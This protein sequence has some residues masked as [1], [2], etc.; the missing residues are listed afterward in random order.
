MKNKIEDLYSRL[1]WGIEDEQKL[2]KKLYSELH[3]ESVLEYLKISEQSLL[4]EKDDKKKQS[5]V[6]VD[7]LVYGELYN[8]FEL[9]KSRLHFNEPV[10]LYINKSSEI[11][12]YALSAL[13]NNDVH[14]ISLTSSLVNM[15]SNDQLMY[16]MG[17]EI[18]HLINNDVEWKLIRSTIFPEENFY[19][20][21]LK[22]QDLYLQQLHEIKAD[23]CGCVACENLDA[24]V[25]AFLI[26]NSGIPHDRFPFNASSYLKR[27]EENVE[28]IKQ[29]ACSYNKDVHPEHP[30]RVRLMDLFFNAKNKQEL[31]AETKNVLSVLHTTVITEESK[32][33][34]LFYITAGY[35]I[36][37]IDG[38]VT[39][40]EKRA[41][42]NELMSY[43]MFPQDE[44]DKIQQ[45][46]V[47]QIFYSLIDSFE[48]TQKFTL[49]D[50]HTFIMKSDYSELVE[51]MLK[52]AIID[53]HIDKK[54]LDFIKKIS[55]EKLGIEERAFADA[56]LKAMQSYF[57]PYCSVVKKCN[58]SCQKQ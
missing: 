22:V 17:H 6:R 7:E 26:F 58:K 32:K 20:H 38:Q 43:N 45:S 23:R 42:M 8:M 37:S 39:E 18:G 2:K 15:L 34:L 35:M 40:T 44:L 27:C 1:N 10:E 48:P 30:I 16:V 11:N 46:D 52:I 29:N 5:T 4:R 49:D 51:Y 31:T 54:E 50:G 21:E 41:M 55:V 36:A 3:A 57:N 28:Y 19:P 33:Y 56:Y 24:A 25:S 47:E 14:K 13:W 12:A 9:A 53:Q